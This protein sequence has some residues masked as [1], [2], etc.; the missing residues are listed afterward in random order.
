[1]K[2]LVINGSPRRD[3]AHTGRVL[4]LFVQ[5]IEDAGAD[6]DII[7]T[8]DLNIGDCRGCFNCWGATPGKC[9]QDDD[10]ADVL[11]K[12]AESDIVVLATPVYVD[13]MTGSLKTLLDRCIPLLHGRFELRDDHCRHPLRAHVKAG[14]LALVSVSGFTE[15]DNFDPLIAHVK[16]VSLNL[17]REFIG[18]LLRPT[19]WIIPE[20]EPHGIPMN[21]VFE[22]AREAGYQLVS[23]GRMKA[24]TLMTVAREIIPQSEIV[25]I[26]SDIFEEK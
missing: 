2:V 3:R 4:A 15:M 23:E 8:R 24:E 1:M 19:A 7:Y 9:I 17:N 18:A 22:A 20:V 14:K 16:A 21:D 6:V 10:M 25:K 5:G 13:G 26:M 12:I 11:T